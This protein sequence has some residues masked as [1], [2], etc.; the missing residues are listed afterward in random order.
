ETNNLTPA[1]R[2]VVRATGARP[3]QVDWAAVTRI[4]N[5]RTGIPEV[6]GSVRPES[7]SVLALD[8]GQET[9]TNAQPPLDPQ[10]NATTEGWYVQLG[11]FGEPSNARRLALRLEEAG[12]KAHLQEHRPGEAAMTRVLVGPEHD[13]NGARALITLLEEALDHKGH[14]IRLQDRP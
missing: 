4:A 10:A 6:V 14:L 8:L 13:A 3:A 11:S 9:T 2:A 7:Q 1:V 5:A 12:F